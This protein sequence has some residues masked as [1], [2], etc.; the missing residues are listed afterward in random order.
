MKYEIN[1]HSVCY[2]GA[3]TDFVLSNLEQTLLL[4]YGKPEKLFSSKE[5]LLI[6]FTEVNLD[7]PESSCLWQNGCRFKNK[8]VVW[9]FFTADRIRSIL[10]RINGLRK[11]VLHFKVPLLRTFKVPFVDPVEIQQPLSVSHSQDSITFSNIFCMK[12]IKG[13]L[14]AIKKRENRS[15][16]V[17]IESDDLQ[18]IEISFRSTQGKDERSEEFENQLYVERLLENCPKNLNDLERSLYLFSAHTALSCWKDFKV[19]QCLSAGNNYSFPRRTYF[20]DGFWTSLTLL[21]IQPKI[22]RD[23]ILA[24]SQGVHEDGCPSAV[25]FLDDEEKLLLRQFVRKNEA[26]KQFVRYENDWWSDHHDSGPLFILLVSEYIRLSGDITVLLERA[27]EGTVLEKVNSVVLQM[28]RYQRNEDGLILKPFDSKDWADNVFRNGLVTYDLALQIAALREAYKLFKLSGENRE[29]L[30]EDYQ[31]MKNSFNK[32]LFNPTNGYFCDFIGTYVEDHLSLDTVVAILYEISDR[33][34][35]LSTLLKMEELLE[36]RNNEYQP[37]GD[38]GVMSV[39]PLYKKRSHLFG[40]SA[41]AYRYHNGSC[42]P[43]LSSAYALARFKNG[44]DP[45][46]GLLKWWEYS[47]EKGWI[48][49]V[50]YYSPAYQRGGLNQA[51]SSFAAY[52]I[53]EMHDQ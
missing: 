11:I 48:N 47:L 19:A 39:W 52:V 50:E 45:S 23:Q 40:K 37:Y 14:A 30:F 31:R 27:N 6:E 18:Q 16:E 25:M 21:K 17:T 53:K 20:R 34:K 3:I 49:L 24:L 8:N 28:K 4:R 15:I 42:W 33:E 29:D 36:S 5:G 1:N 46:Y 13:R 38:W 41:F 10:W 26:I 2:S 51:W 12:V 9:S 35:A 44:L 32:R 7:E 22:V 43:Y